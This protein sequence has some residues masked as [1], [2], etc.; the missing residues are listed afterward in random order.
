MYED[1]RLQL[2]FGVSK[3]SN[4]I[5]TQKIGDKSNSLGKVITTKLNKKLA[6]G[7]QK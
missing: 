6:E 7:E 2:D 1:I 3:Q 5:Q 4:P